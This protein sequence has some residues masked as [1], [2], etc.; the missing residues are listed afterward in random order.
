MIELATGRCLGGG[1]VCTSRNS[2]NQ[3]SLLLWCSRPGPKLPPLP[4]S[5][6]KIFNAPPSQ[7]SRQYMLLKDSSCDISH[8]QVH[9][10][11]FQPPNNPRAPENHFPIC[12]PKSETRGLRKRLRKQPK[13]SIT[14]RL[15]DP[16]DSISRSS[17]ST[18]SSG[19]SEA[20]SNCEQT[21]PREVSP[22]GPLDTGEDS[23]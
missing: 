5:S 14:P 18:T 15:Q 22:L 10:F 2:T 6:S 17:A 20:S 1:R 4:A 16:S 12:S 11:D 23:F 7:P 13:S 3:Y 8:L 21:T 19:K 9:Q